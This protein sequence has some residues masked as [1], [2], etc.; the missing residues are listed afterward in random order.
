MYSP[1]QGIALLLPFFVGL[2][3]LLSLLRLLIKSKKHEGAW[4]A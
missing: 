3:P 1:P 4:A 2:L